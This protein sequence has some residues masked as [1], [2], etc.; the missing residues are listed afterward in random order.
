LMR[1]GVEG[2]EE[3]GRWK[4]RTYKTKTCSPEFKNNNNNSQIKPEKGDLR[5]NYAGA[6]RILYHY[7]LSR[8]S[9]TA[10]KAIQCI[11]R[12]K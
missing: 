5:T 3:R 8:F 2:E 1:V 6:N 4:M 12:N 7:N 11:F 10:F 9:W